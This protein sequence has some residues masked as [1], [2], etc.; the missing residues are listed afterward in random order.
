MTR[1][2]V[3]ILALIN[4]TLL[5]FSQT[6]NDTNTMS[7]LYFESPETAVHEIRK[8]IVASDWKT[9]SYYYD[10]TGSDVEIEELLSG[11]LKRI[12]FS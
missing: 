1:S 4:C 3:L 5:L 10:L 12:V 8:L 7:P 11:E 2:L 9:L 6:D